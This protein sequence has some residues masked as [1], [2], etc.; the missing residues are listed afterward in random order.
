MYFPLSIHEKGGFLT[1]LYRTYINGVSWERN[2][3]SR[4]KN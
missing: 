4:I 1:N 2:T 3:V